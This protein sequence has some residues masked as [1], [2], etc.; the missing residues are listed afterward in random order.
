MSNPTSTQISGAV[1]RT[2]TKSALASNTLIELVKSVKIIITLD[3]QGVLKTGAEP[4]WIFLRN[5]EKD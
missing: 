3:H 4:I 2:C 5:Y 1:N